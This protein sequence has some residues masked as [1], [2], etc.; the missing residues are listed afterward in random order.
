[1]VE[2]ISPSKDVE[3][4]HPH[5][6]GL[7]AAGRP[8]FVPSTAEAV[9][10]LLRFHD[11]KLAGARALVIGRSAVV[12]RPAAA[13]LLN[14][15]ATVTVAHSKTPNLLVHTRAANIV[16]VAVGRPGFIT[17]GM[18]NKRAVV[19]DAGINVTPSGITGDV[20]V[21]SVSGVADALSPVPGGLGAVTTSLMLRN[22]VTA[23]EAQ[24]A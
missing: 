7:L 21:E 24:T 11:V 15:D 6:S 9:I 16:V 22:V 4:M 3:G 17:G 23:A 13:L 8:R 1:M 18:L 5:N 14:E 2:L 12:G 10:E 20:D 19:V